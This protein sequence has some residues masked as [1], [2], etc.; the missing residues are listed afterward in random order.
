MEL[1]SPIVSLATN[2]D[3][4]VTSR[5]R[6]TK[7]PVIGKIERKKKQ[8]SQFAIKMR[9]IIIHIHV[10]SAYDALNVVSLLFNATN[11]GLWWFSG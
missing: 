9:Y 2:P 10:V 6:S 11:D 1:D 8:M 3:A 4:T 5:S 7:Q